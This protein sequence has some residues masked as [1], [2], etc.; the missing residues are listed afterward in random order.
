MHEAF[1]CA[2]DFYVYRLLRLIRLNLAHEIA[3]FVDLVHFTKFHYI[4]VIISVPMYCLL[5]PRPIL[6][7]EFKIL[8]L[9]FFLSARVPEHVDG[10]GAAALLD[11]HGLGAEVFDEG[12]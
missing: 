2:V 8:H 4:L 6:M 5:R 11:L 3:S 12:W 9:Y 10:G 1:A 7:L